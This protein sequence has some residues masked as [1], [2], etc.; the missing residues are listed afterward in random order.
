MQAKK[1]TKKA[2]EGVLEINTNRE[3][4]ILRMSP[5]ADLNEARDFII[6][7]CAQLQSDMA[8]GEDWVVF[9]GLEQFDAEGLTT[10]VAMTDNAPSEILEAIRAQLEARGLRASLEMGIAA[11][12]ELVPV[13]R[14]AKTAA[15]VLVPAEVTIPQGH[16]VTRSGVMLPVR[17]YTL[18]KG[19]YV[20]G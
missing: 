3:L 4:L 20:S 7:C 14:F 15:A 12:Q 6:G 18:C 5:Q 8:K 17:G 10:W 9:S 1:P 11:N 19:K 2:E 13:L 16:T